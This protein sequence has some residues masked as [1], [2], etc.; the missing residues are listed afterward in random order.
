MLIADGMGSIGMEWT[1]KELQKVTMNASQQV[2][3]TNHFI[4]K[5]PGV[6][7]GRDWLED[8][9]TRVDRIDEITNRVDGKPTM[10]KI[11]ELFKDEDNLPGAICRAAKGYSTIASLF[12][13]V[14]DLEAKRAIVTLGRPIEPEEVVELAF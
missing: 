12:N 11:F 7:E 9:V 6:G 1:S 4:K 2:F 8:S 3:H 10:N 14:M 13:I 5:H